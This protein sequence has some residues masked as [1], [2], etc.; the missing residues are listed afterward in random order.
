MKMLGVFLVF[1]YLVTFSIQGGAAEISLETVRLQIFLD[2]HDFNPG[3]IDGKGGKF[4]THALE[5]YKKAHS[6]KE[7]PLK[8]V[9]V[10][11]TLY[12]ITKND[13]DFIGKVPKKPKGQATKKYLGYT[14]LAELV[15]ERHHTDTNFLAKINPN[16]DVK[17]LKVGDVLKVPRVKPFL[18]QNLQEK[19]VSDQPDFSKRKISINTKKRLLALYEGGKVLAS[20]PIVPGS[21]NLPAPRGAW[22]IKSITYLPW[23]RHDEKMLKEGNRSNKFY[24]IPPGPNSPVGIVWI[25]LN[26]KGIGIHGTDSPETLGQATSHGCIRLS[27]WDAFTLSE[28]ITK[29]ISVQID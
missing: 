5:L 23:F 19:K 13:M 7:L 25:A 9:S 29:G 20:F 22:K 27:N 18:I 26:K 11:Y 24:K 15:A 14:N 4:T 1:L 6:I 28:M 12:I 16:I 3:K 21:K 8:E 2:N 17:K 10:L